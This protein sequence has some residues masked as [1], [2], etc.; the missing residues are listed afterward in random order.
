MDVA[1]ATCGGVSVALLVDATVRDVPLPAARSRR[2][3]SLSSVNT[4]ACT[5]EAAPRS[6]TK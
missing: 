6:G 3:I 4:G 2:P 5:F 1:L